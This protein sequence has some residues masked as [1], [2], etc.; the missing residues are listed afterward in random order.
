[1][2]DGTL[3]RS[4][5]EAMRP[6]L[7]ER[8]RRL[9]CAAEAR[10]AGYGGVSAVARA[11]GIA[12]STINRGLTDLEAVDPACPKVRRPGG[13]RPL[14]TQTDPTLLDD[15]RGLLDSTT[16]GDPMRPLLLGVQEP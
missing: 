14:L 6:R 2:I 15:L 5:F 8:G 7:D 16:L 11:T 1:M 3:I 9:F 12:R 4:R 10:S 13:G